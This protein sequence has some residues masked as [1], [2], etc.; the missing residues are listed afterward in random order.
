MLSHVQDIR[1]VHTNQHACQVWVERNRVVD[2]IR[3]SHEVCVER[4]NHDSTM[5]RH[6]V[7]ECDEVFSVDGQNGTIPRCGIGKDGRIC[8]PL[9]GIPSLQGSHYVVSEF[10]KLHHC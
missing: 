3:F 7:V 2:A 10:P 1:P 4:T 9:I 6:S 5:S 8:D